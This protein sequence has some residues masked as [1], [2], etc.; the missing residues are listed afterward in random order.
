MVCEHDTN[1]IMLINNYVTP[2]F[3]EVGVWLSW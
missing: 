3:S 1:A 2:L